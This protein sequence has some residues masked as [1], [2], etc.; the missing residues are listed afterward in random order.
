MA[1]MDHVITNRHH[2]SN[3]D[4]FQLKFIDVGAVLDGYARW[5]R[6]FEETI[7]GRPSTVV[8]VPAS[9]G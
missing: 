7:N 9:S 3:L 2:A 8:A 1:G 6:I 5:N 4:K